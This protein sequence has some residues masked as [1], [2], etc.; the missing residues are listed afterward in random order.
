METERSKVTGG[1]SGKVLFPQSGFASTEELPVSKNGGVRTSVNPP[2]LK[3]VKTLVKRVETSFAG[4][5]EINQ[6]LT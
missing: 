2:P 4:T 1:V 3:A 6:R 5:L